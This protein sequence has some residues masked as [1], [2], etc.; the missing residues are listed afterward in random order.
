MKTIG[1]QLQN[2]PAGCI[3][4]IE[5]LGLRTLFPLLSKCLD[6]NSDDSAKKDKKRK[7]KKKASESGDSKEFDENVI[8][9]ILSLVRHVEK[10]DPVR[11]A[12]LIGKFT[13]N[14]Y[15]KINKLV[16]L[17]CKYHALMQ[18]APGEE[19]ILDR[20]DLGL[21]TLQS[22]CAILAILAAEEEDIRK[23][24]AA[25]LSANA[26]DPAV[27]SAYVQ[28]MAEQVGNKHEKEYLCKT[29]EKSVI[30]KTATESK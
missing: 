24:L 19:D 22:V 2:N 30:F 18:A 25:L 28:E 16:A 21:F 11:Y 8:S 23:Y 13:E 26:I 6:D 17:F 12:R 15:D 29:L 3:G 10:D 1:F 4:F 27:V 20:F 9:C 5:A 14:S 7:K